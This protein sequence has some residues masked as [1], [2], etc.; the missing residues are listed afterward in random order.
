MKVLV[1]GFAPFGGEERNPSFEAVRL[2]PGE[3]A[4]ARVIAAETPV[5]VVFG[6]GAEAVR[7]LI[8]RERPQIV[9]CVGQAGGRAE[10]SVERLAVNLA[11]ARIPDNDG[12]RPCEQPILPDGPAAYFSTLPVAKMARAVRA[13][14]IPA[15]VSL[16]AGTFVCNDLFYRLLALLDQEYPGVRG[17]FIHVPYDLRQAAAKSAG[18]PCLPVAASAQAVAAAIGAAVE[19]LKEV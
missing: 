2:L 16:S 8:G 6:A 11:D 18:A 5:P 3:I 4:G 12:N 9:V 13:R 17:G 15:Q 7:G 10:V 1:T 14:G 19:E